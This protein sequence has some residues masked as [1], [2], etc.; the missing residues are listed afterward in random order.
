MNHPFIM[1]GGEKS[2]FQKE[3]VDIQAAE[4]EA[5]I[6]HKPRERKVVKPTGAVNLFKNA[7]TRIKQ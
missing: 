7:V 5:I 4:P 3:Q 1:E 6:V 2:V